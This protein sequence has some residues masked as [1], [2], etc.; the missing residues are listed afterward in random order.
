M[1]AAEEIGA[2]VC[3]TRNER[4][5]TTVEEERSVSQY[6]LMRSRRLI[7]GAVRYRDL[8]MAMRFTLPEALVVQDAVHSQFVSYEQRNLHAHRSFIV[9]VN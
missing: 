4:M 2:E 9:A 1:R 5:G 8:D 6:N 7:L 3:D